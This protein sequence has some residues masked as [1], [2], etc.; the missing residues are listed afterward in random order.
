MGALVSYLNFSSSA[1]YKNTSGLLI[2]TCHNIM[3]DA[4]NLVVHQKFLVRRELHNDD[5]KVCSAQI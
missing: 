1:I 4:V 5:A 2:L 3:G